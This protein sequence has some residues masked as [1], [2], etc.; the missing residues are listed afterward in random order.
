MD[1]DL[2][3]MVVITTTTE[4]VLWIPRLVNIT[5]PLALQVP[6]PREPLIQG[7]GLCRYPLAVEAVQFVQQIM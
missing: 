7:L 2:A 4:K 3:Y 5:Y 1:G 6:P